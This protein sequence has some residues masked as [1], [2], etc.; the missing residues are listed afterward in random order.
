MKKFRVT[1][2]VPQTKDIEARDMQ[3]AHNQV[4]KMMEGQHPDLNEPVVKILSINEVEPLPT[5]EI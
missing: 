1:M 4:S 2:M 3:D 5:Q